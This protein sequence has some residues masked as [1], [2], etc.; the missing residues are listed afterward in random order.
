MRLTLFPYTIKLVRTRKN[1]NHMTNRAFTIS[2]FWVITFSRLHFQ[3]YTLSHYDFKIICLLHYWLALSA[4]PWYIWLMWLEI[5]LY[6]LY[7]IIRILW[8]KCYDIRHLA[9]VINTLIVVIISIFWHFSSSKP[10]P[11]DNIT[12]TIQSVAP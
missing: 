12:H 11:F 5:S 4:W 8:K 10:T 2:H 3:Y 9:F 7:A 1:H 6:Y